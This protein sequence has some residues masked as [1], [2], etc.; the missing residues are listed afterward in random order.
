MDVFLDVLCCWM[1][2]VLLDVSLSALRR[3][4]SM[5]HRLRMRG[6]AAAACLDACL[7]ETRCMLLLLC[8]H[9]A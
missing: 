6:D 4:G 3:I 8:D 1:R 7:D 9:A 2:C 5:L